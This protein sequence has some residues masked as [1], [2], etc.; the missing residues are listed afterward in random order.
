M[1]IGIVNAVFARKVLAIDDP[2]KAIVSQE[3]LVIRVDAGI[4]NRDADT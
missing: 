4:D 3:R 1:T 2:R